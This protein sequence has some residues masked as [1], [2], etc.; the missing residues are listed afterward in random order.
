MA[1]L[2]IGML[3]EKQALEFYTR[4]TE[5]AEDEDVREFFRELANLEDGHYRVLLRLLHK[6]LLPRKT[7]AFTGKATAFTAELVEFAENAEENQGQRW[8]VSTTTEC[9]KQTRSLG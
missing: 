8:I 7:E 6:P 4:Q 3:L 2:S 9:A 5:S 1:A